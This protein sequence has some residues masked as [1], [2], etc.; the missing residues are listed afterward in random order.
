[1]SYET[2]HLYNLW[3]AVG[4]YGKPLS[5]LDSLD[6]DGWCLKEL[7]SPCVYVVNKL[8]SLFMCGL[9]LWKPFEQYIYVV[10][11]YVFLDVQTHDYTKLPLFCV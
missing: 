3:S 2:D 7:L 8:I 9:V 5:D 1:M 10:D 4:H 11:E 6:I